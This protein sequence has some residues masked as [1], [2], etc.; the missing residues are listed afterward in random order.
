MDAAREAQREE[1]IRQLQ[2]DRRE[3]AS[4]DTTPA[5]SDPSAIPSTDLH[6]VTPKRVIMADFSKAGRA[7]EG[8]TESTD[9]K[10]STRNTRGQATNPQGVTGS[11]PA[12]AKVSDEELG[13][14]I[15]MFQCL[16]ILSRDQSILEK[17]YFEC[18]EAVREVVKEVSASLDELENAYIAAVMKALAKWQESGAAALQA[19][20]TAT[21][22][23]WD[24]LHKELIQATVEFRNACLEAETAKADGLGKIMQEIANGTRKD[25]AVEILDLA[26][27]RTRKI[28]DD[29]AQ[30]YLDALK[31]SWL[32]RASSEQLPMLVA[33]TP[34]VLMTF[35]MAVW[36]LISD[37]SVWP[38]RLRS[39]GFCKMA[40]IVRQSLAMIL[41]LC[42]LVVPPRPIEAPVPPPSPVQS[43]IMKLAQ[44][45]SSPQAPPS[46]YGSGGSTPAGTPTGPKRSLGALPWPGSSPMGPPATTLAL[47]RQAHSPVVASTSMGFSQRPG[48]FGIIAPPKPTKPVP[49]GAG[50]GLPSTTAA[51][52]SMAAT[53]GVS[54]SAGGRSSFAT[55]PFSTRPAGHPQ[56]AAGLTDE[57]D[58][59][60][61]SDLS[62]M[63]TDVTRKHHHEGDEEDEEEEDIEETDG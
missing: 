12:G 5:P 43:Y 27:Q 19:M 56:P 42:G 45:A 57:G 54:S 24:N 14:C 31:D 50:R 51:G 53:P 59:A 61:D 16:D 38:S 6:I 13:T 26:S 22:K 2:A 20:H 55:Y 41:T 8:P 23:E 58:E 48:L 11:D 10:A 52:L 34:G 28:T 39:A 15:L 25:P 29:A 62:K 4:M 35:R 30:K 21:T 7:V 37:E 44:A 17:G 36:H 33:S 1:R 47:P 9:E 3:P 63:A 18:V 46:G 49:S 32:G 60:L 40:P